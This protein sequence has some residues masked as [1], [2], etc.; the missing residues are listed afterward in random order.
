[1]KQFVA[2]VFFIM[3]ISSVY[4]QCNCAE[5]FEFVYSKLKLNYA[6]WQDKT[7]HDPQT[8]ATFTEQHRAKATSE[9]N[10]NYC[11]KIIHDWLQ[12]FQ[13]GHTNLYNKASSLNLE[14]KTN[15]EIR[16]HF[17]T[18][19]NVMLT[20]QQAKN[21]IDPLNILEG[22]W[23][24][25][26]YTIA[27][28][29]NKNTNRDYIGVIL[30][31]DSVFW[32]PGQVKI[33]LQEKTSGKY[34]A[35]FY[36]RDHSMQISSATIVGNELQFKNLNSFTK[37]YPHVEA[38]KQAE[39]LE[40][41]ST[42]TELQKIDANTFYLRLPTFNHLIKSKLDSILLVN[43]E[44]LVR[45]PN[46]IIDV[47]DNGGG[48]DV[49]YSDVIQYLYTHKIKMINNSI[50]S[51]PDNVA[52]FNAILNDPQYP[53]HN[54]V[55][56]RKLVTELEAKPNSFYRKKDNTI[57]LKKKLE[58]PK[59]ILV[60]V[61]RGCASSCEEFVLTAA[62]SKKVTVMGDNTMG[63]LDYGNVHTLE[64]PYSDWG[65]QYATSRTNRLPDYPIDNIGIEPNVKIPKDVNWIEFAM[66]YLTTN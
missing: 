21:Q 13:D 6:G 1:M 36:M 34:D 10:S 57:T 29:K 48:S 63:V 33:E 28:I 26:A 19:E 23:Q 9:N 58:N 65:L 62:Q 3:S 15:E 40:A 53:K 14:G 45:T 50:L 42:Q 2:V 8:F 38:I 59:K 11:Y 18:T 47:R 44:W 16:T 20:E 66:Q 27:I 46:L 60:L 51:T 37:I 12:Y 39:N 49:T 30:K 7:T 61:N 17:A 41:I 24:N 54:K 55:Y 4:G 35:L 31:A 52:K 43:H 25:E 32:M 5:N 22:I 64:L 56:I